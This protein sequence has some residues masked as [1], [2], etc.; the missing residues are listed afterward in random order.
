MLLIWIN[1][2]IATIFKQDSYD[3]QTKFESIQ[4]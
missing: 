2:Q 4:H 1:C 3:R